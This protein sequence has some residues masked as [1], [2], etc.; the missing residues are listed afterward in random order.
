MRCESFQSGAEKNSKIVK[1]TLPNQGE[2]HE[3]FY[4]HEAGHLIAGCPALKKKNQ[5]PKPQV[6]KSVGFVCQLILMS[7]GLI[8]NMTHLFLA[9]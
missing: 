4:C 9:V 5:S 7:K 3:C 2:S 1:T 8:L 6:L